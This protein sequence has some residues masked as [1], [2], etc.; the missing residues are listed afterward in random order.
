MALNF[1]GSVSDKI[2]SIDKLCGVDFTSEL[3]TVAPSRS[4]DARNMLISKNGCVEKRTGYKCALD[5]SAAGG[6]VNGIFE[7]VCPQN[8]KVYGLVHIGERLYMCSFENEGKIVLG[9]L[10][11]E[12][13]KDKKSRGFTFGGDFYMIGAG[14]LKIGYDTFAK[15]LCCGFVNK[16]CTKRIAGVESDSANYD[17]EQIPLVISGKI[18]D[19]ADSGESHDYFA[20]NSYKRISFVKDHYNFRNGTKLYIA[21][22]EH[23]SN[24]RV[25]AL[26]LYDG[27]TY[28]RVKSYN[29]SVGS[30]EYG[31]YV[32]L[33]R[34]NTEV[35][36]S[37]YCE[38]HVTVCYNNFVYS[39]AIITGRIPLRVN[40]VGGD[41]VD[42]SL[43]PISDYA[44]Y[45]GEALEAANLA[46]GVRRIEFTSAVTGINRYFLG[47]EKGFVLGI[48]AGAAPIHEYYINGVQE[49]Y[50]NE[51]KYVDISPNAIARAGGGNITIEYIVTENERDTIDGCSIYALY[52]GSNDTRVF[53]SG[54]E[55]R[56]ARDFASGLYDASY[57]SD[58]M[59]TDV[60]GDESAIVGYHKLYGSLVIVKDGK[61]TGAAQ[62]LRTFSLAEDESGNTRAVFEVRQGGGEYP[63][64]CASSFKNAD[65]LPVYL[66][67]DG[68]L[69]LKGTSVEGQNNTVCI[70][71][72]INGRLK[73]EKNPENAVG[74]QCDGKYYLFFG[75]HAYV[76]VP[77]SGY[78]WF[79]FDA[80]PE[81]RCALVRGR[82]L[83]M[84]SCDGKI[85][86]FMAE[87]EK[88]A[89]YDN[90]AY[91]G[92]LEN[93]RAIEAVWEIAPS[94]LGD[95]SSYKTIR[96]CYVTCVPYKKS[97]VRVFYNTNEDFLDPV[98]SE[99]IDLFSF[100]AVDFE[101]F[102][103][104][105]ISAPFV[106]STSM[107][108]KNVYVFGLRL[109]NDAAGEPFGVLAVSIKYRRGKYVK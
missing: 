77:E 81:V 84:G 16:A 5:A 103:F 31:T 96:S 20:E 87:D 49:V 63:A 21:T 83:Y 33:H 35:E 45:T 48:W 88:E 39:P 106:F 102:T 92:G 11:F 42:D 36:A 86:R 44:P 13:L 4:P 72:T 89:Y 95:Y 3:S 43:E 23:M 27:S 79:W 99:N 97:S 28:T 29:Y 7:Y 6:N 108:A 9:E 90:V 61:G 62:Y 34:T 76:C 60:G 74:A 55:N 65:G 40:S 69:A 12:G 2:Y 59:Y 38:P 101:R 104:K 93:A 100:E 54:N 56:R 50:T 73:K 37:E 32:E 52:G 41:V 75:D 1:G 78:E 30:D 15:S 85:Y 14:Y 19:K 98:M 25:A 64:I 82:T 26:H 17:I 66:G 46:S 80:L 91:D 109:V 58:L 10:I 53:V 22:G 94:T 71:E 70:S 57:F 51:A 105:T 24:V 107:K 18:R 8:G 68:V 47:E 67:I